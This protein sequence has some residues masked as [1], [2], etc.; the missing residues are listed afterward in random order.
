MLKGSDGINMENSQYKAVMNTA[1][2]ICSQLVGDWIRSQRQVERFAVGCFSPAIEGELYIALNFSLV[3]HY[4]AIG[5]RAIACGRC[6]KVCKVCQKVDRRKVRGYG[7]VGAYLV[8][9]Q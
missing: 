6:A 9:T 2:Q 8:G 7:D 5:W 4:F 1:T 3:K